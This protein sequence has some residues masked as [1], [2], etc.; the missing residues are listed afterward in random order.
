[1]TLYILPIEPMDM[2]FSIQW[3]EWFKTVFRGD[4]IDYQWITPDDWRDRRVEP[5]PGGF[6]KPADSMQFKA[7]C[8]AKLLTY[9]L[10]HWDAVLALDGEYP[11][12]E[13]LEYV[14]MMAGVNFKIFSIWHAGTYDRHDQTA[15]CGLTRI[16]TRLEEVLFDICDSVFVATDFHKNLI[17]QNRIVNAERIHVTGLPVDAAMLQGVSSGVGPHRQGIVFAGR[18]TE[19]KG[20]DIVKRLIKS[21]KGNWVI[22]HEKNM[23][24]DDYYKL[25]GESRIIVV[26][27]RQETFGYAAIEAISAGCM[28][29]IL[30]GTCCR[31]YVPPPFIC[32]DEDTMTE[33]IKVLQSDFGYEMHK[34]A[35]RWCQ[36]K[37]A[38]EYDYFNVIRRM[39]AIIKN[40]GGNIK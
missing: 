22:T 38:A 36:E 23:P 9:N 30:A 16:G 25:L 13:A 8:I 1:M 26:P 40:S 18:L 31:E 20:Y 29:V 28:P 33:F 4:E 14:R 15:K 3:E 39:L 5:T 10:K 37:I 12:L 24:K 35:L 6:F 32:A 11:G 34:D 21:T 27:S 2:R 19:E 17:K 7:A